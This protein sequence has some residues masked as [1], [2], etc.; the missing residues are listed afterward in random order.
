MAKVTITIEDVV[1]EDGKNG[2]DL[3][4]NS[5]VELGQNTNAQM[6]AKEIFMQ[7]NEILG[8]SSTLISAQSVDGDGNVEDV[9]PMLRDL[10]DEPE[11]EI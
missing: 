9:S 3:K 7:A 1:R 10:I 5:D 6:I 2:I 8:A 4:L 11:E